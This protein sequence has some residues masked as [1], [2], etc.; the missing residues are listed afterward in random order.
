M[1]RVSDSNVERASAKGPHLRALS[2]AAV[3]EEGPVAA[4]LIRLLMGL[5]A[6][7]TRKAGTLT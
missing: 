6:Y 3:L 4:W 1:P 7:K 2:R 5:E